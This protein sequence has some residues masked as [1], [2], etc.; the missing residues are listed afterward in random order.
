MIGPQEHPWAKARRLGHELSAVLA[1]CGNGQSYAMIMPAGAR[2]EVSFGAIDNA[3]TEHPA[4][5]VNRLAAEMAE[6]LN[7]Y[8][9][10]NFHCRIYPSDVAGNGIYFVSIEA[11]E[12]GKT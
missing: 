8:M 6:A 1:E 5:K 11:S 3:D 12:R 4:N 7:G 2:S 9:N 10:G